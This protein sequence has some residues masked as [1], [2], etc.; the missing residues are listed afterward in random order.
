MMDG[1]ELV[2]AICD[3]QVQTY[4]LITKVWVANYI[5]IVFEFSLSVFGNLLITSTL[6]TEATSSHKDMSRLDSKL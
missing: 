2:Y 3:R 6:I 5:A 4:A 1:P